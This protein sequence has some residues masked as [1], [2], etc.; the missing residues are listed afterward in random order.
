MNTFNYQFEI[1]DYK[2]DKELKD[3]VNQILEMISE[4]K[5]QDYILRKLTKTDEVQLISPLVIFTFTNC[6]CGDND[7]LPF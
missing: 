3:A 7:D 5:V 4:K 6:D 1:S 2:S